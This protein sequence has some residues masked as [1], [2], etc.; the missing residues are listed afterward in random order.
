[1]FRR[2]LVLFGPRGRFAPLSSS[3]LP[4]RRGVP[5][6]D[7]CRQR[8]R[9]HQ[10]SARYGSCP[11]RLRH[12][13]S[14]RRRRRHTSDRGRRPLGLSKAGSAHEPLGLPSE[15]GGD[16]RPTT[17]TWSSSRTTAGSPRRSRSSASRFCSSRAPN[18]IAEAYDEIRQIGQATGHAGAATTVVRG[19]QRKLTALI[20]SV[21][22][23]TRH[24]KVFHE[25]SPDYYTATSSTF[26]GRIYRS[27]ASGTSRTPPTR[28]FWLPAALAGVHHLRRIPTSS[29]SPTRSVA[30]RRPPRPESG[31]AGSSSPPCAGAASLRSTTVLRHG[32]GRGS[33]ISRGSSQRSPSDRDARARPRA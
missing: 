25:L 28:A 33:S 24:L 17:P 6:H 26:I 2:S 3:A 7:P 9:R 30:G 15:Y 10:D 14:L 1:M 32:G 5:G 11:S 19:M 27:S 16:R 22:K 21:P 29:C 13:G 20:R 31:R 12:R 23:R 4:R 8:R 18:T